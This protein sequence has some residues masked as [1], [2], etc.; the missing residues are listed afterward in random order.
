MRSEDVCHDAKCKHN[1]D[2]HDPDGNVRTDRSGCLLRRF[3]ADIWDNTVPND[4]P[5]IEAH[6]VDR[7]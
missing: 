6:V 1:F 3:N 5:Y 7:P 4:C 2:L